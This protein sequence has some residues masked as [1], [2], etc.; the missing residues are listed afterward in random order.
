[1][2]LMSE[3][4]GMASYYGG[5]DDA[6]CGMGCQYR[7]RNSCSTDE[8]VYDGSDYPEVIMAECHVHSMKWNSEQGKHLPVGFKTTHY[9]YWDADALN[10]SGDWITKE[11][12]KKNIDSHDDY[13][14]EYN[15]EYYYRLH[16]YLTEQ[17]N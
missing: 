9:Q 16:D 17:H 10:G 5:L 4:D 15:K 1:M 11:F 8:T 3:E 6:S 7:W 12:T 14:L 2:V 13:Q